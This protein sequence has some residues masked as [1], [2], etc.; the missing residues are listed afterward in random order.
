[1]YL[2]RYNAETKEYAEMADIDGE[3]KWTVGTNGVFTRSIL[4]EEDE[5]RFAI[6]AC[7]ASVIEA[8][9]ADGKMIDD[10]E[11]QVLQFIIIYRSQSVAEKISEAFKDL[12]IQ[13]IIKEID[14][15]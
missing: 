4:L 15:H 6:A 10:E 9:L 3:A 1:M 5:N 12:T 14:N 11:I 7:K 2:T 8:A 13:N